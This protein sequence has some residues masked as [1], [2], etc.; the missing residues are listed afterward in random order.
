MTAS[1]IGKFLFNGGSGPQGIAWHIMTPNGLLAT[2][3]LVEADGGAHWSLSG[4]TV[5]MSGLAGKWPAQRGHA[6]WRPPDYAIFAEAIA[7]IAAHLI[8]RERKRLE[9]AS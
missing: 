8:E 6:D 9:A 5:T 2:L 1:S 3:R 7:A 4:Y